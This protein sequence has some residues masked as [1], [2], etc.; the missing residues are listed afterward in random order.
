MG[1]AIEKA[2]TT[3]VGIVFVRDSDP[4]ACAFPRSLMP[5]PLTL[6][7]RWLPGAKAEPATAALWPL[8]ESNAR[9]RIRIKGRFPASE[10]GCWSCF[11]S[12]R[13]KWRKLWDAETCLQWLTAVILFLNKM[14]SSF[15]S[16]VT[17]QTAWAAVRNVL[18]SFFSGSGRWP[19]SCGLIKRF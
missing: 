7:S 16:A 10:R 12:I 14:I 1:M 5:S 2:K 8:Q 4:I 19:Q 9:L 11:V 17:R 6:P 18:T 13:Q 3:G 15:Y